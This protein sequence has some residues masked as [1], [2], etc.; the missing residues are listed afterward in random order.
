MRQV[1]RYLLAGLFMMVIS[2]RGYSVSLGSIFRLQESLP[3]LPVYPLVKSHG[4][5]SELN[6]CFYLKKRVHLVLGMSFR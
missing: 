4:I 1:A 6:P 2:Q 5:V 3:P